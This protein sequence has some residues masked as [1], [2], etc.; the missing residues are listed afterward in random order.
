MS[1]IICL[2]NLNNHEI[3]CK[4]CG[5]ILHSLCFNKLGC[6]TKHPKCPHCRTKFVDSC[7][8]KS[9]NMDS[10]LVKKYIDKFGKM[11]CRYFHSLELCKFEMHGYVRIKCL[12]CGISTIIVYSK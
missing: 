11:S 6:F 12:T 4:T 9:K 3:E 8:H 5:C 1:C 7:S 10:E 2:E